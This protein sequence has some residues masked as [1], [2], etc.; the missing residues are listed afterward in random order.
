MGSAYRSRLAGHTALLVH[1]YVGDE[2]GWAD[3]VLHRMMPIV[4]IVDWVP[5]PVASGVSGR[6]IAGR[7]VHP[8]VYGAYTLGRGPIVDWY[9]Y[10]F[11]DPRHQGYASMA[12]GLVVLVIGFGLLAL[13]VAALGESNSRWHGADERAPP[14]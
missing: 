14:K 1:I 4:M 2:P 8:L 7:L 11:I 12:V 3:D 9:P 10:L 6:P 13:A 5:A